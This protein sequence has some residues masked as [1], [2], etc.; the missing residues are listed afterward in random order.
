ML[1]L[2]SYFAGA[3]TILAPCILPVLPFVFARTGRPFMSSG[4]PL[5]AGM[6]MSFAVVGTLAAVA[7]SWAVQTNEFGRMA[8]LVVLVIMGLALISP[9]MADRLAGPFVAFGTRL[10]K[11]PR[12]HSG[13]A[14]SVGAALLTG[15]ATG[16]I[17]APCAGPILGVLLTG[18]ALEGPSVRTTFLLLAYAAGAA[19]SLGL[20]LLAGNRI[21]AV[22]KR[23]FGLGGWVLKG[24]G[25]AV[26]ASVAAV[27]LGLDTG[28]L[29]KLPV[30]G[31]QTAEK[32]LLRWLPPSGERKAL[33]MPAGMVV[34]TG[35]ALVLPSQGIMPEISG[36]VEWLN[37]PAL[38]AESLRG[39]VVLV[40]F[41]TFGCVNCRNALPHVRGWYDKYKDK[42]LVV[43]GV[44]SPE[45]AFE[46]NIGNVKRASRELDV[47]FPV[48][49]DN[50]FTIWRAFRNQYW[51][52]LYLIDARG[53]V[54][55][56]H[57]GEGEYERTEQVIEQLLDEAR[58][59][60]RPVT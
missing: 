20:A 16:F 41:W 50:N 55:F 29:A 5:M 56:H 25:V 31:V 15:A 13:T 33:T 3:L 38:T 11:R 18:A 23:S 60:A 6:A 43:V 14:Q 9:A 58:R 54:R 36:A 53:H 21:V 32:E 42:G 51:P 48:A 17:W 59:D 46:K 10:A 44:H 40:D 30:R 4:L 52:A 35:A 47:R 19:T 22:V 24:A 8:A 45:F 28:A 57:F 1:Y 26:L 12:A 49:V 7:G 39:K 2:L 37:S 27:V 34:R